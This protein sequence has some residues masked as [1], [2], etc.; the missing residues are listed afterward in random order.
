MDTMVNIDNNGLI[1]PDYYK[2][3]INDLC[4]RYIDKLYPDE[5]KITNNHLLAIMPHIYESLFKPDH[6]L[7]NNQKCNIPY[8]EFNISTLYRI[9]IQLYNDY[10]C[11]PS[12]YSFSRLTGIDESCIDKYVTGA[13][14][15][16][17]NNRREFITGKLTETPIGV[18]V[19]ANNESS[20]GLMYNRQNMVEKET[21]KQ[22]LTLNDFIKISDKP[23]N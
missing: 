5:K 17:V 14:F 15:E 8:N 22:G 4:K 2:N 7:P 21:I 19:L 23:S 12:M 11:M 16:I 20:V 1:N 18:T 13:R 6:N 3:A 10:L 9:Y